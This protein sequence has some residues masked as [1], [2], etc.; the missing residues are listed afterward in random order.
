MLTRPQNV[1]LRRMLVAAKRHRVRTS[2]AAADAALEET[3]RRD[4][5]R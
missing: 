5:L 4:E 2:A 3:L 1:P